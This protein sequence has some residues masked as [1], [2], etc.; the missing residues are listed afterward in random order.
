MGR[1]GDDELSF[2][3]FPSRGQAPSDYFSRG[4][5]RPAD[6]AVPGVG[7]SV[8]TGDRLRASASADLCWCS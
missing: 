4:P 1:H 6:R 3:R 2:T 5:L 7:T 8:S